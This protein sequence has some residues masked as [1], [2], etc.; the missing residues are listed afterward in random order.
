MVPALPLGLRNRGAQAMPHRKPFVA[1]LVLLALA[2]AAAATIYVAMS[3]RDLAAEAAAIARVRVVAEQPGPADR[4]PATDYVVAVDR[5]L[6]GHLPGGTIVV[7][8]PGGMR[9]DGLVHEI[10][11]TPRLLQGA[12]ALL[13]LQ[14]GEDGT[15]GVLHLALGAFHA[16][17]AGAT[18]VAEQDLDGAHRLGPPPPSEDDRVRDLERFAAWLEDRGAGIERAADYWI[19]P[20]GAHARAE[21]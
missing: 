21:K 1:A 13:F 18:A 14:P 7:R 9:A 10:A 6:Q 11:G 20:P 12:E 15:F 19:R 17:R 4:A 5:L 8:V 16:R 3:D 2:R